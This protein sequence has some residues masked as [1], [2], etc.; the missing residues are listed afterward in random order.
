MR[1]DRLLK[2]ADYLETVPRGRFDMNILYEGR[3]CGFSGCA[4]GWAVHGRLF[5]GLTYDR[6]NQMTDYKGVLGIEG[7]EVLLGK[8]TWR[9][10]FASWH[11]GTPKQVAKRIRKF[12]SDHSKAQST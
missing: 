4:I 3:G 11:K 7:V 6:E 2:L 9:A 10:L 12:V 5:R 8:G 1:A